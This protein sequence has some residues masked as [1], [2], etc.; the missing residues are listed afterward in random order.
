MAYFE[1]MFGNLH[2]HEPAG[3]ESE[4]LPSDPETGFIDPVLAQVKAGDVNASFLAALAETQQVTL[5]SGD[6]YGDVV[7]ADL[8]VAEP[9]EEIRTF[10]VMKEATMPYEIGEGYTPPENG[11]VMAAIPA[12]LGAAG[13]TM[14]AWLAPILGA[15]GAGYGIWQALGGGEGEGLFGLDILGGGNGGGNGGGSVNGIPLGGPGLAEPSAKTVLKEWHVSYNWGRL[16]YYLVQKPGSGRWIALYN[17]RTKKWKAW[18][19]RKPHLAV[20]GKNMPSHKQL[21][22][23]KRNMARHRADA[24]TIMKLTGGMPGQA[25]HG[26]HTTRKHRHH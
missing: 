23:L 25:H 22:R 16:Q 21:T 9:A 14:P 19:W 10:E 24:K 7:K 17:T 26:A 18:P 2:Y 20:I 5:K 3:A 13:L 4:W 8:Q 11:G 1:D 6:I 12:A 15:A